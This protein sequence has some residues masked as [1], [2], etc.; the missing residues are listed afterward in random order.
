MW[1]PGRISEDDLQQY[2]KKA[3][4]YLDLFLSSKLEF[5]ELHTLSQRRLKFHFEELMTTILHLCEYNKRKAWRTIIT[6]EFLYLAN[7]T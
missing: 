5:K 3:L 1:E 6:G 4:Y 2:F 7:I